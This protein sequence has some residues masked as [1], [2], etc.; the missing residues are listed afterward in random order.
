MK[1][2]YVPNLTIWAEVR[3]FKILV[4]FLK[5]YIREN[6]EISLNLIVY[7]NFSKCE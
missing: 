1:D 7:K 5:Y 2:T 3:I 6:G 4:E